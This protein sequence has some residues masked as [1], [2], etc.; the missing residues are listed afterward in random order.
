[1]GAMSV[2]KGKKTERDIAAYFT[3]NG[4]PSR[5]EVR[6]GDAAHFDE[7][8]IRPCDGVVIEVKNWSGDLTFGTVVTLLDKLERQKRPGDLGLLIDRLDRIADPGKWRVWMTVDDLYRLMT[9]VD[10]CRAD[11]YSRVGDEPVAV[12]LHA[13]V[14]W[15]RAADY[16]VPVDPFAPGC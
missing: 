4:C 13:V 14:S 2:N 16:F 3:A 8:D 11:E 15:L 12:R 10:G 5:R 9:K 7:G 6:T 1:M